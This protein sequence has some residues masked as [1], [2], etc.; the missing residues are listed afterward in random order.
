ML[1]AVILA[2]YLGLCIGT[3]I[4]V[5][6]LDSS[7]FKKVFA[8]LLMPLPIL[9]SLVATAVNVIREN[10]T[11]KGSYSYPIIVIFSISLYPYAVH[12]FL[13]SRTLKEYFAET[14]KLVLLNCRLFLISN[15]D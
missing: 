3:F 1:S 15:Q 4:N 13:K 7:I 5:R 14:K 10:Q 8:S 2:S 11:F 9:A 6:K 12:D